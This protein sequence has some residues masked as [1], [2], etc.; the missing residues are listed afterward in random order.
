[1]WCSGGICFDALLLIVTIPPYLF[2]LCS[3]MDSTSLSFFEG[4]C[5]C[6]WLQW[7]PKEKTCIFE[8]FTS[9]SIQWSYSYRG[10]VLIHFC[11]VHIANTDFRLSWTF[12]SLQKA[13]SLSIVFLCCLCYVQSLI[14]LI[15]LLMLLHSQKWYYSLGPLELVK[16]TLAFY[17]VLGF[18]PGRGWGVCVNFSSKFIFFSILVGV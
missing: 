3:Y 18:Y 10:N 4:C 7:D 11:V 9:Q 17:S 6:L 2:C 5:N 12:M 13:A 16:Q 1:M 14:K 8:S 15:L